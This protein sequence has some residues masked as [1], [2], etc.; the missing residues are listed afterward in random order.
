M[1]EYIVIVEVRRKEER[2]MERLSANR[3]VALQEAIELVNRRMQER[4]V[5]YGEY[6]FVNIIEA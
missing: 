1:R 6:R 2:W 4:D 5:P 3:N